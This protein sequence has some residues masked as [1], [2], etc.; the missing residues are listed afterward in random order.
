MR[1]LI[2][3]AKVVEAESFSGAAAQLGITKSAV[4]KLIAGLE[5]SL[6]VRVLVRTTRRSSLTG[7]GGSGYE[8]CARPG[9]DLEAVRQAAAPH[10]SVV[11]H[12]RVTAPGVLGR[13]QLI[14][15]TVEFLKLHPELSIEVILSDEFLDV[16]DKRIDVALRVRRNFSDSSLRARR[17]AGVPL[18]M[19]ASPVYLQQHGNPSH[20]RELAEHHVIAHAPNSRASE[21]TFK[22]RGKTVTVKAKARLTCNDGAGMISAAKGSLGLVCTPDFEVNDAIMRGYLVRVLKGWEMDVFSLAALYPAQHHVPRKVRAFVDFIADRWR[23][24]PWTLRT[25]EKG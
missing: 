19:C 16:F 8:A 23:T 7:G 11:G 24:P 12:L 2:A 3:F 18:V 6:G 20:P 13:E 4:S 5:E 15:L 9:D 21:F 10:G 1:A 17:L 25:A 14:P 22:R